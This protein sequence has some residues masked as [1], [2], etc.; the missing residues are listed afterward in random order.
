MFPFRRVVGFPS[1]PGVQLE[2]LPE[3]GFIT[4]NCTEVGDPFLHAAM[5]TMTFTFEQL[6][7]EKEV[8]I[9]WMVI[10]FLESNFDESL[11]VV[12]VDSRKE[13]DRVTR[14]YMQFSRFA[15][16]KAAVTYLKGGGI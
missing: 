13:F 11:K 3:R 12:R 2:D 14:N 4:D 15:N 8:V 5:H 16:K 9:R 1:G 7:V 6:N 10:N